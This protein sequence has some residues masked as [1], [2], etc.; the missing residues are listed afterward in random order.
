MGQ[1]WADRSSCLVCP[2]SCPGP[3][4]SFQD[5]QRGCWSGTCCHP[6]GHRQ[7][8]TRTHAASAGLR[9]R[10]LSDPDRA[11]GHRFSAIGTA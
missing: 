9:G 10:E 2:D 7:S 8:R 6:A 1:V 3:G 11:L 4:R 5:R